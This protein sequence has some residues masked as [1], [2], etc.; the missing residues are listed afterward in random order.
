QNNGY[1]MSQIEPAETIIG[2]DSIDIEVKV[3]EG[4]QFQINEVGITGNQRVD[5]E[6]IRRELRTFPGELYDRSLLMQTIRTLGS[7]GHFNPETIMPDIKPVSDRL[8]NVNWPLEEQASDQFNIAGGWGSGTFV[9]SVGITL[10]NLSVK[11]FFKKGAWRPYPMGQN[12]RLSV[13]AQTNGTYY[14]AF[15]LSFTDPWL[16]GKKP[17]SFT[18]SAHFSEQN[19]AYYVWQKSTQYFRTYGVAAGLGKR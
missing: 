1:L 3:F 11:N 8:V 17:N 2:P 14:K 19:N 15:A 12:Q 4:K 13:S 7:M 16:G 5:D 9:G 6:V 18:I 10:N